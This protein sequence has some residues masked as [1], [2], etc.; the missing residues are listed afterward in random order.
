MPSRSNSD[1]STSIY[2]VFN[3]L[4]KLTKHLVKSPLSLVVYAL[5]LQTLLVSA[6]NKKTLEN[7]R[8]HLIENRLSVTWEINESGFV[9]MKMP[10]ELIDLN[11]TFFN[12]DN[13]GEY[14]LRSNFWY[15]GPLEGVVSDRLGDAEAHDHP[16]GFISYTVHNGYLHEVFNVVSRNASALECQASQTNQT[17]QTNQTD[18]CTLLSSYYKPENTTTFLGTAQLRKTEESGVT[19]GDIVMFDDKAVHRIK[20]FKADTLTLN[21]VRLDGDLTTHIYLRP[22]ESNE[23]KQSRVKLTGEA[24][25]MITD[26]AIE[27]YNIAISRADN[28]VSDASRILN[29]TVSAPVQQNQCNVSET[30]GLF[31][32]DHNKHSDDQDHAM[33][34]QYIMESKI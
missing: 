13:I 3:N 25:H 17:N 32:H 28:F 1:L 27:I 7:I 15:S 24:A 12:Q 10:I 31:S 19:P 33:Q 22:G 11:D 34:N 26:E 9:R 30:M 8:D 16:C 14:R 23:V 18:E 4:F 2:G 5:S 20:G 21:A 6:F 29:Y